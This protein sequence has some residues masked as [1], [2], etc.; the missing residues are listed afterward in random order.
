MWFNING[1]DKAIPFVLLFNDETMTIQALNNKAKELL[2]TDDFIINVELDTSKT[3]PFRELFVPAEAYPSYDQDLNSQ[4]NNNFFI[5][6][7]TMY[8][9]PTDEPFLVSGNFQTG[10]LKRGFDLYQEN[11]KSVSKT[12]PERFSQILPNGS[13]SGLKLI[14]D[15]PEDYNPITQSNISWYLGEGLLC[16]TTLIPTG[17]TQVIGSVGCYAFITHLATDLIKTSITSDVL[18]E[19]FGL[20]GNP[21]LDAGLELGV[22]LGALIYSATS[23]PTHVSHYQNPR[24]FMHGFNGRINAVTEIMHFSTELGTTTTTSWEYGQMLGS[25][26]IDDNDY[27]KG[28]TLSNLRYNSQVPNYVNDLNISYTRGFV[29]SVKFTNV[30]FDNTINPSMLNITFTSTRPMFEVG[31]LNT[32]NP[33]VII[34][35]SSFSTTDITAPNTSPFIYTTSIPVSQLPNFDPANSNSWS[36]IIK[37]DVNSFEAT[38]GRCTGGF[39]SDSYQKFTI[40]NYNG[41]GQGFLKFGPYDTL[42]T[43]AVEPNSFL[44]PVFLFLNL[45]PSS[46]FN[47]PSQSNQITVSSTIEI[48]TSGYSF[49]LPSNLE[50]YFSEYYSSP[51]FGIYKFDETNNTWNILTTSL[52]LS[53][54]KAL[55]SII[56]GGT[57]AVLY[58]APTNIEDQKNPN[59]VPNKFVLNQNYPNPFNPVTKISYGLPSSAMVDL[60]VY[61]I[62][63]EL[64]TTLV[65]E[66]KPA[67]VYEI[68]FKASNLPSGVYLYRMQADSFVETKKMILLK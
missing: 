42:V 63:G 13:T 39:C 43:L 54:N 19:P 45:V 14:G 15:G 9:G 49:Q 16:A 33:A 34:A 41:N 7:S 52:L 11:V 66:E 65:N 12:L 55:T 47:H 58:D 57:Y 4:S 44:N 51:S 27:Y 53:E 37:A 24:N 28:S 18:Q 50:L 31:T 35:T 60:R 17:V 62:L 1:S 25:H 20:N 36:E 61:N 21:E 10:W 3:S 48:N 56:D 67:G 38:T 26:I 2:A 30:S 32:Q 29:P 68:D 40:I 59:I 22:D 6:Y 23:F 5:Y 46:N 64:I 8:V